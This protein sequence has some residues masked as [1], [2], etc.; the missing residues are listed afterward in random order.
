M[1]LTAAKLVGLRSSE[2]VTSS[3]QAAAT[4]KHNRLQLW[5]LLLAL[6]LIPGDERAALQYL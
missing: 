2:G 6:H 5:D 4:H 1:Q 3:L